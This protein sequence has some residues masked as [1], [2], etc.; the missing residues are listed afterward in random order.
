M[1]FEVSYRAEVKNHQQNPWRIL[2]FPENALP[3][4]LAQTVDGED[5]FCHKAQFMPQILRLYPSVNCL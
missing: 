4:Q 2:R 1:P 5:V 3:Q